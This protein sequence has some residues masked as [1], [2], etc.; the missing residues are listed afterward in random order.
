M[1]CVVHGCPVEEQGDIPPQIGLWWVHL[2][3][4]LLALL[5]LQRVRL[6]RLQRALNL[7]KCLVQ[8]TD[9]EPGF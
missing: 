7:D 6:V 1:G 5:L 2:V 9:P 3:P 4:L 8:G